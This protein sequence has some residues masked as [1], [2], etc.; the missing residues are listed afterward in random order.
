MQQNVAK[1]FG[2]PFKGI[3]AKEGIFPRQPYN[4]VLL[5]KLRCTVKYD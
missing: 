4:G 3:Y 5:S 1:Y 2:S